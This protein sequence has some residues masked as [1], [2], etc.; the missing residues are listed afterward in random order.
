MQLNAEKFKGKEK[1]EFKF[2]SGNVRAQNIT[3]T[4]AQKVILDY[5]RS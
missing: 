2:F 5:T 3:K 1:E 4:N